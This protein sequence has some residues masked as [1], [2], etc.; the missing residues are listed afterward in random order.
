M[1]LLNEINDHK[2]FT[3]AQTA[4]EELKAHCKGDISLSDEIVTDFKQ[5]IILA[6]EI[7][8]Y[9]FCKCVLGFT[10]LTPQTH[11][12]W[13]VDLQAAFFKHDYLMRLK[14]RGTFKTTIYGESFI[15]WAWAII[16]PE[17]RFCYTSANQS[18]L[19]E[20]SAHLDYFI[21]DDSE[22]LYSFVFEIK[23][24]KSLRPNTGDVFNIVGKPSSQKGSSLI[25]RTA[26]GSTNGLHPHVIIIDDPMDRNDRESATIREKKKRWYESLEPLLTPYNLT[27]EQKKRLGIDRIEKTMF[28]ATRWHMQDLVSYVIELNN[29]A[30]DS[31]KY[32]IESESIYDSEG[33]PAYPEFFGE[34]RINKI[35][36]KMNDVF[37]ACQY[38]NNPL[39][40]NLQLFD[41]E[42]F[43]FFDIDML[44]I[45]KGEN[46]CVFDPSRGKG[47]SDYPAVVWANFQS[48]SIRIFTA[49]DKK[50]D[51]E[52]LISRIAQI[53]IELKIR[54]M[55]YE[56]NGTTLLDKNLKEAHQKIDPNY[57]ICIEENWTT[58]N[59]E[60]RIRAMQPNIHSGYVQFRRDY[61]TAYPELINQVQYFPAWGND[62]FPD[63]IE[64]VV[65]YFDK[66]VYKPVIV[67][68]GH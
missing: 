20:V 67:T 57:K 53:N 62:D 27:E 60:E 37:F 35:K 39:P 65:Q 52:S 50:I 34:G 68:G 42:K 66:P 45:T 48:G 44:D 23:R 12:R 51:L 6:S 59:K 29:G 43:H 61:K 32:D 3:L 40:E 47:T 11:K 13:C 56:G 26:G 25:F 16:S 38:K 10:K 64:K 41:I 1:S 54:K 36:S 5:V 21:A 58:N 33:N 17:I 31:D 22:S 30:A 9:F 8:F 63:V 55:R 19:T 28:I 24:D 46:I 49:I 7:S 4:C 15:L 18:L 2:L 14:P